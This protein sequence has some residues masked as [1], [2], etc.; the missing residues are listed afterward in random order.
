MT[1]PNLDASESVKQCI[2][3]LHISD[4]G[5]TSRSRDWQPTWKTCKHSYTLTFYFTQLLA[6]LWK[7]LQTHTI[8]HPTTWQVG[9]H[10]CIFIHRHMCIAR[11]LTHLHCTIAHLRIHLHIH[12]QTHTNEQTMFTCICDLVIS[13]ITSWLSHFLHYNS[14]LKIW[15]RLDYLSL[16]ARS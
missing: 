10:T 16:W 14:N 13:S 6:H 11:T 5:L 8:L 2:I 1:T 7:N 12:T 15:L 4:I 9:R 3:V